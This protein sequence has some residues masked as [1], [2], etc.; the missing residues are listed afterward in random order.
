MYKNIFSPLEIAK[1]I[2]KNRLVFGAHRLNFPEGHLPGKKRTAYYEERAKG[3]VGMIIMEGSSVIANY[4]PYD[5]ALNI[6]ENGALSAYQNIAAVIKKYPVLLIGQLNHYGGQGDSNVS[7]LPL[8]APS[9]VPEVGTNE[10]P[11]TIDEDDITVLRNGFSA[12]TQLLKESGFDGVEINAAQYSLL[13][14][15]LSPLTNMRNDN[16]GGSMENRASL[17]LDILRSSRRILGRDRI[18]GLRLC[19]DEYAP[20]GGLAPED[21]AKIAE[22]LI[23]QEQIDYIAVENGSLYSSHMTF[24]GI[25]QPED[26]ALESAYLI[27]DKVN[28]PVIAGGS[29]SSPPL[30]DEITKGKIA[31]AD[32]TRPLIADP[33]YPVKL[34]HGKEDTIRPCIFCKNGCDTHTFANYPIA[35]SVNPLCGIETKKL[36]DS[37]NTENSLNIAIAGGGPAGLTAA[38]AASNN[39]Y[40]VTLFEKEQHLGGKWLLNSQLPGHER[41]RS[42]I[43]YFEKELKRLK[44]NIKLKQELSL[45]EALKY[46]KVII[47]TG[48]HPAKNEIETDGNIKVLS[49]EEL[50]TGSPFDGKKALIWDTLGDW[51]APGA[52]QKLAEAGLEIILV[53]PDMYLAAKTVK[54]GEFS[55]WYKKMAQLPI[56]SKIQSAIKYAGKDRVN[57]A[58]KFTGKKKYCPE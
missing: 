13:R 12:G 1:H 15:F 30:I 3:G 36:S 39:G 9:P 53:T 50:L 49:T 21:L 58:D 28:I 45:A 26:Y 19:G 46:D 31:L 44:I 11:K 7:R 40:N 35:C 42:L 57:I 25:Y 38:L 24:G 48:T 54:N 22:Y 23:N 34:E 14:Q 17:L 33:L 20:W 5:Y 52:C 29:L 2:T 4:Y 51:R 27:A 6:H 55:Y 43:T 37:S 10:I 32:I 16:Y 56:T 18:L 47:A 41:Y 8:L